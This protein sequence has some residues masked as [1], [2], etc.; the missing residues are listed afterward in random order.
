MR[1]IGWSVVFGFIA[2]TAMA[3]SVHFKPHDPTFQDQ[4]TTLLMLGS[5]AGLANADVTILMTATGTP[6]VLCTNRGGGSAP[7][8]NP[9]ETT[10]SGTQTIPTNSIQNGQLF[11]SL[12]TQPP[13]NPDGAVSCPNGNWVATVT[14]LDFSSATITVIQGGITVLQETFDL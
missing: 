12:A 6:T 3:A 1:R 2:M 13:A 14:D 10:V 4:G 5:L 7:G 8:Q 11:V 9:G